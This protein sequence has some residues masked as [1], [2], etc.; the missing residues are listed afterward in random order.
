M[1]C[2]NKLTFMIMMAMRKKMMMMMKK[3]MAM[4]R[5]HNLQRSLYLA[6]HLS[7][8]LLQKRNEANKSL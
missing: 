8:Q 5:M 4:K 1:F 3:T 2:H 7:C 6:A